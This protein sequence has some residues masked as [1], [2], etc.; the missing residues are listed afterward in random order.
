MFSY[1]LRQNRRIV[2][3]AEFY[4][5]SYRILLDLKSMSKI[6]V[7]VV[8]KSLTAQCDLGTKL[9][10]WLAGRFS[11]TLKC[12]CSHVCRKNVVEFAAS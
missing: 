6:L 2:Y 1:I 10:R 7:R 4:I 11:R 9:E 8:K 3:Y 5:P 12:L